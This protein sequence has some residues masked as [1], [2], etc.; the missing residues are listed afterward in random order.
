MFNLVNLLFVLGILIIGIISSY[1]DIKYG[2]IKNKV[3]VIGL[4]Y[5]V[6]VHLLLVL[7][8]KT[9]N[10]TAYLHY[11]VNA[12][13]SILIS[14][15]LWLTGLWT[16]G[17]AKLFFLFNLLTPTSF[18]ELGYAGFFYGFVYFTNMFGVLFIFLFFKILTRVDWKT[19]KYA[20]K[21]SLKPTYV[22]QIILFV[23]S[24]GFFIQFFPIILRSN[25]F[26]TMSFFF[27]VFIFL[28]KL[29]GRFFLVLIIGI[30]IVRI[31]VDRNIIQTAPF[32]IDLFT[33]ATYF[34]L[35]R[36]II[37][38]L[39][40]YAFTKKITLANL[41]EKMFLAEDIFPIESITKIDDQTVGTRTQVYRKKPLTLLTFFSYLE[42]KHQKPFEYNTNLGLSEEN[43]HWFKHNEKY[44]L[45]KEIRIY[46]TMYFAPFIFAGVIITLLVK[47]DVFI[48]LGQLVLKLIELLF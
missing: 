26:I 3:I 2:K 46:E 37:L 30:S 23:F 21:K 8:S 15:I 7:T 38:R 48:F 1:T 28:R 14:F 12:L 25:F 11:V 41:E 6:L 44:I 18:I 35:L 39:S 17:D 31:F 32:W 24:F 43:L 4:F 10:S 22:L 20:L 42:Q 16:A 29:S 27:I 9:I 36:L 34:I 5:V 47:G 33:Q 13:F 40:Y 19:I 45:F